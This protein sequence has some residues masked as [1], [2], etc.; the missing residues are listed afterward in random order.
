MFTLLVGL[1]CLAENVVLIPDSDDPYF[2]SDEGEPIRTGH[3]GWPFIYAYRIVGSAVPLSSRSGAANRAIQWNT[4]LALLVVG[5]TLFSVESIIRRRKTPVL[6]QFGLAST[7]MLLTT[8]AVFTALVVRRDNSILSE[9]LSES[10]YRFP[11]QRPIVFQDL[12]WW[13]FFCVF[14]IAFG[15]TCTIYTVCRMAGWLLTR[16]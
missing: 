2:M 4:S 13:E 5:C 1:A 8:V 16:R 3:Y 6:L 15:L 14:S 10:K 11:P 9:L 7:F 12:L